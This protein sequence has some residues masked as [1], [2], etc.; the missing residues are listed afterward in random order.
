MLIHFLV[1]KK[2]NMA[3]LKVIKRFFILKQEA[4]K[5]ISGFKRVIKAVKVQ[6]RKPLSHMTK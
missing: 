4:D 1:S 5:T 6:E 2:I 3:D